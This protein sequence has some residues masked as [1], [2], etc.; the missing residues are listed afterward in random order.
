MHE[1]NDFLYMFRYNARFF[2][3]LPMKNIYQIIRICN[4]AAI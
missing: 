3:T 2:L 1:I 4:P